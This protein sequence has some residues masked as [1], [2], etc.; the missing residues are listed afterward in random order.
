MGTQRVNK[1]SRFYWNMESSLSLTW[2]HV[3]GSCEVP[4]WKFLNMKRWNSKDSSFILKVHSRGS[5]GGP[6][7]LQF[8]CS[9]S[10]KRR[11]H[12]EKEQK[13]REKILTLHLLEFLLFQKVYKNIYFSGQQINKQDIHTST[14]S[15]ENRSKIKHDKQMSLKWIV[16]I[17]MFYISIY[18]SVW[19]VYILD[20]RT[21]LWRSPSLLQILF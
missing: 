9:N 20:S 12:A 19:C 7:F 1:K 15:G 4:R 11:I 6:W 21:F 2:M 13:K 16:K 3:S 17:I 8:G 5:N 18:L 14:K 10:L